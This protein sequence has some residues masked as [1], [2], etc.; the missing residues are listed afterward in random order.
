[1]AAT[2]AASIATMT[3]VSPSMGLCAAKKAKD[4]AQ[5]S[6]IWKRKTEIARRRAFDGL[7]RRMR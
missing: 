5:F 7:E 2:M 4:Q 6:A 3:A 1:M